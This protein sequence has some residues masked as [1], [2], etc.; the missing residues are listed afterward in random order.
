MTTQNHIYFDHAGTTPM[1]ERV[2]E[3]MLP[4]FTRLFGNASSVHT[5]GQEARYALDAARERVAKV[6]NCRNREVVFTSGGTESDNAAIRGAAYALEETGRHVITAA[7]EHHAVLHACQ[8]LENRGW[9]VTYLP[10]DDYGQV[11]PQQ[12]A[13]AITS[14]TA[15]VSIMYANNEIGTINPI[16]EISAAVRERAQQLSRT[17]VM[18]TDAV[19]AAGF[20]D[21]DVRRLGVDMMS[22]S[23]HKFYGPKGERER[24]SGTENVAGII[25]LAVAL[26]LADGHRG[27][28]GA[29]CAVLRDRIVAEVQRLVPDAILNGHPTDRLPNNVN[30]SFDG[31]EGESILLG[32][33]LQGIA[34][35]SGSACSS[36]SLEPSHV[37]LALGQT[38]D[39]ARG[40][41]RVTLGKYN[42]DAEVDRLLSVLTDL[43]DNLRQLPTLT[44]TGDD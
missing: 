19:Q 6:L 12:V 18:H 2:L 33:D 9:E 10:V 43:I 40:S 14:E 8:M 37:L 36:G 11:D 31:V 15:L 22:L 24:R 4:Y 13:N 7:A 16:P 42:T 29:H 28:V 25:G 39:T 17:I 20:L 41:L 26:E 3:A 34:A 38:A 5:V 23:G 44:G 27:E 32:L 35:S 1:D 30:F 21:L